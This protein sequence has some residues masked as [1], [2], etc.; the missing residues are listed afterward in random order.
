MVDDA[1]WTIGYLIVDT[2]NWWP[3]QHVLLS[4]H[5]VQDISYLDHEIRLKVSRAQVKASPSWD[6][7]TE[8]EL[9]YQRRLHRHYE[10]PAY[11]W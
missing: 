2:K 5:A 1:T 3:G 9:S 6:P 7:V 4:P 10:W 11:G 8:I